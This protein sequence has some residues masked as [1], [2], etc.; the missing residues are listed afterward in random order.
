MGIHQVLL[1]PRGALRLN[2]KQVVVVTTLDARE[3]SPHLPPLPFRI[4]LAAR[5]LYTQAACRK[6]R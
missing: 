4:G 1:G 6:P 2:T 5:W 3:A